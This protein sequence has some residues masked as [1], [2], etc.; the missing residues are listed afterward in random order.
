[1]FGRPHIFLLPDDDAVGYVFSVETQNLAR[2]QKSHTSLGTRLREVAGV[3]RLFVGRRHENPS[4]IYDILSSHNN[5]G[6]E[7]LYLN[8]GYWKEARDYDGAC[9]ALALLLAERAQLAPGLEVLD[10]GFGFGDQDLLWAQRFG[11][12]ITGFNVNAAQQRVAR[13]RAAAAGLDGQVDFRLGSALATQLPAGSVDRVVALESAFHFPSREAFFDEA[14]RVLRP[15]GRIALAD[16]CEGRGGGGLADRVARRAA[17][18]F[19]QIPDA[20]CYGVEAYCERL[21]RAGFAD[22]DFERINE[23]VFAPFSDH[24]RRRQAEAD[25]VARANPL[26]R[27]LWRSPAN[28]RLFDYVVIHARRP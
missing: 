24:A 21:R 28:E 9:A 2:W 25:V 4:A 17:N 19:W 10:A 3:L 27:A 16:I 15:G 18:A 7:T 1:V 20:N 5:L 23:H 8:L 12:R 6:R 11:V 26:M 22:V 13:E 14:W